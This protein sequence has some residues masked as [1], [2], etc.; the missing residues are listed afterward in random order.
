MTAPH[1]VGRTYE[2]PVFEV[3]EASVRAFM[4]ATGDLRQEG[5]LIAPP[6]YAMVYGF[7]PYWQLFQDREVLLNFAGLVHG[8]QGFTFHRAVRPGDR[9]RATGRI[10]G[11]TTRGDLELVRFEVS[12]QDEA[13]R[14]VS[15]ATALFVIRNV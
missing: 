5:E 10:G 7:G 12:A 15:D 11:I 3:T 1:V 2:A 13:G 6:T 14:A 4:Q 8:E 9:I